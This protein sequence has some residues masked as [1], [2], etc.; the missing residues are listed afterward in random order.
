M[1]CGPSIPIGFER[2]L[3]EFNPRLRVRWDSERNLWVVE[4]K[5]RTDGNWYYV[6]LWAE[7]IGRASYQFRPLPQT[8]GPVIEKLVEMDMAR[9]NR[10]PRA[11]WKSLLSQLEGSR[12]DYMQAHTSRQKDVMKQSVKDKW[13]YYMKGRRTF[14]MGRAKA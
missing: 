11:A 8:A 6:M 7:R 3:K 10:T 2:E 13:N 9:F 4:E 1:G 5:G 14:D 12:R